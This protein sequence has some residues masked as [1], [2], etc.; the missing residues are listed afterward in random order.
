MVLM[1]RTYLATPRSFS[2]EAKYTFIGAIGL[3]R[4]V[5]RINV[6][7]AIVIIKLILLMGESGSKTPLTR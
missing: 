4:E 3:E 2:A 6:L 1:R 5:E 7:E